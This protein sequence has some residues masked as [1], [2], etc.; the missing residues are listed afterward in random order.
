LNNWA[1][2]KFKAILSVKFK[3]ILSH[4]AK[5]KSIIINMFNANHCF[6]SYLSLCKVAS[7]RI[8][9]SWKNKRMD[10]IYLNYTGGHD[11]H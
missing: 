10:E 1:L 8:V 7:R 3:A 9:A 6:T 5:T 4:V 11:G 2:D